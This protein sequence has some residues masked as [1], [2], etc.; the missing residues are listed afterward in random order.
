MSEAALVLYYSITH[1]HNFP[2]RSLLYGS[3]KALEKSSF[4]D[5][6]LPQVT[7]NAR[8]TLRLTSLDPFPDRLSLYKLWALDCGAVAHC[9]ILALLN[10]PGAG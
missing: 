3:E 1:S 6:I 10:F 2:V 7:L 4:H 5:E 8:L 9:R